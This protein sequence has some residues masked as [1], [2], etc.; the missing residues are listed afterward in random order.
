MDDT[1]DPYAM[2]RGFESSHRIKIPVRGASYLGSVG[3]Q[4]VEG[5][6]DT[7]VDEE[8]EEEEGDGNEENIIQLNGKAEDVN[9]EDDIDENGDEDSYDDNPD[10]DDRRRIE[11]DD[12]HRH[13][14]KRKMK[15]LLSSYEFAPR[16]TAPL[17]TTTTSASKP[18]HGGRNALSDW[19]EHE[20]FVLLNAWGDRF[21]QRRRK[22]LRSEE[23]QEVADKVSQRSRLERTDTQCRNRLDTLKKKYKKEK[24]KLH[25][26][27]GATSQWVYFKKMDMLLSLTPQQL[28]FSRGL[29]YGNPRA[30][31]VENPRVYLNRA[32]R[33]DEMSN[34]P[35]NSESVEAE[36]YSS[37]LLPQ[38]QTNRAV[39]ASFRLIAESITKFSEIYVKVE[40]NKRKQMLELEKMRMDFYRELEMQKRQILQKARTEIANIWRGDDSQNNDSADNWSRW[41]I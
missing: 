13:P 3:D 33:I 30:S 29:N 28:R 35:E 34:S 9:D 4:Y 37:N 27:G 21:I 8:D 20:T 16:V 24:M 25:E 7:E 36:E 39:G 18:S 11:I 10:D 17:A 31:A 5:D 23:W 19:T 41:Y 22:S 26:M 1:E 6:D 32:S 15:S 38:N 2:T 14:K 12:Q 40:N